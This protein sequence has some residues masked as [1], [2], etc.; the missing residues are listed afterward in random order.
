VPSVYPGALDSIATTEADWTVSSGTHPTH[1]NDLADAVNKI[2]A[3]LGTDPSGLAASLK[4]R[5]AWALPLNVADYGALGDG[6]TDD[7]AALQTAITAAVAA[8]AALFAPPG[9]TY[10]ITS[11]L[12]LAGDCLINFNGSMIKKSTTYTDTDA[13]RISGSGWEIWNLIIDGNRTG[14]AAGTGYGSWLSGGT[15]GKWFNCTIQACKLNGVYQDGSAASV[16]YRDCAFN[17]NASGSHTSTG[18]YVN[19]GIGKLYRCEAYDNDYAGIQFANAAGDGC[20]LN[21]KTGR[22]YVYGCRISNNKGS[23]DYFRSL[24]DGDGGLSLESFSSTAAAKA[25]QWVLGHVEIID[26]GLTRNNNGTASLEFIGGWLNHI[27]D[28]TVIRGGG[29]A[30][31]LARNSTNPSVGSCHNSIGSYHFDG[32][33]RH[34]SDPAIHISGGSDYNSI[35]PSYIRKSGSATIIIGEDTMPVPAPTNPI[36]VNVGNQ[37]GPIYTFGCSRGAVLINIGR[38]NVIG[39]II[40]RDTYNDIASACGG[41]ISFFPDRASQVFTSS[42]LNGSHTLPVGTITVTSTTG[43]SASGNIQIGDQTV[44]Y[45]SKNAT[46]FLDC[47]GGAGTFPDQASVKQGTLLPDASWVAGNVVTS[48]NH[49]TSAAGT[50]PTHIGHV[51][52]FGRGNHILD[53][54]HHGDY[55]TA[56]VSNL[57][58]STNKLAAA[59]QP[60]P[61]LRAGF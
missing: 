39:P 20:H 50:K 12:S 56:E 26:E 19:Q 24:D 51:S 28:L 60:T 23:G 55:T 4:A 36:A 11:R 59:D 18:F 43:F 53:G 29:Y 33:G 27:D 25:S 17:D 52:W 32:E 34:D 8:N 13:L 45:T 21:A 5:L 61:G 16:E 54:M 30:I 15:G 58:G 9:K 10:R 49:R 37:I 22:N 48:V 35:G 46:Q 41:L 6:A 3:E 42:P 38:E 47:T 31:A 1:H 44:A 40:S 2:E 14:G 7:T 57:G